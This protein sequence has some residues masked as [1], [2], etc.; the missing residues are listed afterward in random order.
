MGHAY[1]HHEVDVGQGVAQAGAVGDVVEAEGAPFAS[2]G[3]EVAEGVGTGSEGDVFA[4]QPDGYLGVVAPVEV[5]GAGR[6]GQ[7]PLHEGTGD[8]GSLAVDGGPRLAQKGEAALGV[9]VDAGAL[10]N[11]ARGVMQAQAIFAAE[12]GHCRPEAG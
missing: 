2:A 7:R 8:A 5:E 11:V 4:V 12:H 1:G 3:I 10:Q 6:G 9:D